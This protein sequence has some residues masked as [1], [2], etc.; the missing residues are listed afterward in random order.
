ML[1]CYQ[2]NDEWLDCSWPD[3]FEMSIEAFTDEAPSIDPKDYDY[4]QLIPIQ[5][6]RRWR[7]SNDGSQ[8]FRHRA[9]GWTI[10]DHCRQHKGCPE[11][12]YKSKRRQLDIAT[13]SPILRGYI[14]SHERGHSD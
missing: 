14:F 1:R 6:Y 4:V 12:W 5:S 8:G 9:T 2:I 3:W 13:D 10:P 11:M 7:F